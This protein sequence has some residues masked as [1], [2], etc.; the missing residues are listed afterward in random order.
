MATLKRLA[1]QLPEARPVPGK[2]GRIGAS[3]TD[4]LNFGL[5]FWTAGFIFSF[6]IVPA[7]VCLVLIILSALG[8]GALQSL[9]N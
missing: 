5:G 1:Q 4:G 9:G 7:A 3:F 2:P 8:G 6:V